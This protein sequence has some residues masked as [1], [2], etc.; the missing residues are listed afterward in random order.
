MADTTT[1]R[2]RADRGQVNTNE[3]WEIK[4]WTTQ[5]ACTEA[6]LRA[7]ILAAGNQATEVR[8]YLR[9]LA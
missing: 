1:H 5:F 7:A 2:T 6:E 4:Y 9:K 3:D 8:A